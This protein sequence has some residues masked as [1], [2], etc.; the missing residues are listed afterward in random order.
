MNKRVLVVDDEDH[1]IAL[2]QQMFR[3]ETRLGE[4]ALEFAHDGE[5]ALQLVAASSPPDIV[6]ILSD[7]DMPGMNA[8]DLL[9]QCKGRWPDLPVMI[10][11]TDGSS[12]CGQRAKDLGADDALTK[13]LDFIAL[14]EKLRAYLM[15]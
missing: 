9:A 3:Q 5:Q 2:F 1:A 4:I 12:E 6:L 13:P 11:S 8:Q 14:K 15:S 10:I 7:I